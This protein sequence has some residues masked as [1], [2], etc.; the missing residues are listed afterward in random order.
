VE[1]RLASALAR[2]PARGTLATLLPPAAVELRTL[3]KAL[4]AATEAKGG[5][6]LRVVRG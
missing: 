4:R 1:Y 5:G 6:G 3:T 2:L